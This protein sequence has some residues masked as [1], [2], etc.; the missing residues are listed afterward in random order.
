MDS[1]EPCPTLLFANNFFFATLGDCAEVYCRATWARFLA[2]GHQ[3][4]AI[5]ASLVL[6]TDP[7]VLDAFAPDSLNG[8]KAIYDARQFGLVGRVV[9][10][11]AVDLAGV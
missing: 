8:R 1:G 5:C 2:M 11:D 6:C 10:D 7:V 9:A 4:V 3:A